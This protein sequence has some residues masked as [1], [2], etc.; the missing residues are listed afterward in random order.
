MGDSDA[1]TWTDGE[2]MA[3]DTTGDDWEVRVTAAFANS[4]NRRAAGLPECSV[5]V[6]VRAD[7]ASDAYDY[8]MAVAKSIFGGSSWSVVGHTTS[9]AGEKVLDTGV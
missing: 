1:T 9:R 2:G 8:A 4:S 6:C 7:N 3:P 5:V